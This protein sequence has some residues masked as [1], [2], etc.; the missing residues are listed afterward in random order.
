[1]DDS[2]HYKSGNK[3]LLISMPHNASLIPED[4]ISMMTGEGRSSSDTD[5]FVERLYDFAGDLGVHTVKPE[6]SR[7]YIDLN[8]DPSG[9]ELYRGADNTELCPTSD[10]ASKPIYLPGSEP[11]QQQVEHRLEQAWK[12]YHQC[13]E[14]TLSDMVQEFGY[15]ILFDAHSIRSQVPRFFEGH[16]PDFNYGNREGKSCSE[17]LLHCIESLDYRPWSKVINGR[18]K[19]GYI[20]SHYG[21]PDNGIHAIQLELSQVTYLDET[22]MSWDDLKANKVKFQLQMVIETLLEWRPD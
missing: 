2:F 7:Y 17:S 12:P 16:L 11:E 19:G 22:D 13:I 8:R 15:A 20:T 21:D 5:W 4:V 6:W 10:F 1:M 18:F 14:D 9:N 3:P